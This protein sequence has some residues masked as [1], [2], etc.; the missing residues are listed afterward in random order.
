MQSHLVRLS[1]GGQPYQPSTAEQDLGKF[2]ASLSSAW[3]AGE[4]RP[5]H[6][7]ETKP[8]AYLRCIELV[9]PPPPIAASRDSTSK[10]AA[11]TVAPHKESIAGRR[12]QN[13]E[14]PAEPATIDTVPTRQTAV[15]AVSC[16]HRKRPYAFNPVWPEI[17]RRLEA[18]PNLNA[19]ELFDQLQSEYPGR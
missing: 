12:G 15:P 4:I 11:I 7:R 1:D 3:R 2:L 14:S 18:R 10:P 19:S 13:L 17:C 8:P 6:T 9:V 16:Q 5:T